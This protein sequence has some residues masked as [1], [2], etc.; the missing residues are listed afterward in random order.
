MSARFFTGPRPRD[1]RGPAPVMN[2]LKADGLRRRR[3]SRFSGSGRKASPRVR[4]RP[5][6]GEQASLLPHVVARGCSSFTR[7]RPRVSRGPAPVVNGLKADGLRRRPGSRFSSSGRTA[8]PRVRWR[9]ARGE[10]ASLLPPVAARVSPE[11]GALWFAGDGAR[12]RTAQTGPGFIGAGGLCSA[13]PAGPC[14]CGGCPVVPPCLP[15]CSHT[16]WD[17]RRTSLGVKFRNL[18][19]VGTVFQERVHNVK[20]ML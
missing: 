6:R 10:Q 19:L 13:A 8:S 16:S 1:S 17:P 20:T 14:R 7:P 11:R 5:A 4:W 9:P 15:G 18:T 12:C 3:G 2:G